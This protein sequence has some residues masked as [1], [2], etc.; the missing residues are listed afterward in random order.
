MKPALKAGLLAAGLLVGGAV[1]WF[2]WLLLGELYAGKR[3]IARA[4]QAVVAISVTTG[5]AYLLGAIPVYRGARLFKASVTAR[6]VVTLVYL[7]AAAGATSV[8]FVATALAF[9]R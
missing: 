6:F 4:E 2:A 1:L 3:S 9:N 7:L 5:L 8:L